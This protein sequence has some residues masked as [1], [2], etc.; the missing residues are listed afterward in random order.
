M[1]EA[2]WL[3][4]VDD[5]A[6]IRY[7]RSRLSPRAM[8]LIACGWCRLHWHELTDERSR[9]A[10]EVGERF[11]D[12]GASDEEME[13]AFFFAAQASC[14]L[15][16]GTP[17]GYYKTAYWADS[18]ANENQSAWMNAAEAAHHSADERAA[19]ANLIR[20][21]VG[22]PFRVTRVKAEW[23]TRD[24][25]QLAS[26]IYN[27]RTFHELPVLA[28]ALEEVGCTEAT[29]LAHLRLPGP[30]VRGCWALDL[31]LEKK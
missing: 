16:Q 29:I 8:R 26:A 13:E 1:T 27:S 31:I 18:C 19:I 9:I 20:E 22:N 12:G 28:D 15:P 7:V 17:P 10:V 30:H 21:V 2:E 24:V 4:C 3:A 23:I 14:H 6:M 25:F 11:A 5:T